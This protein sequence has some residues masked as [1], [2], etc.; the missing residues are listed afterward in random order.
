[1][2]S[3]KNARNDVR[4]YKPFIN[5]LRAIAIL[6]VVGSHVG[7]PGF[8][9]GYV[10]VDVF[11]VISGYLIINQIVADIEDRRFSPFEFGGRR[12]LRILPT[13][14]FVMVICLVLATTVFVQPEHKEFSESF[15]LSAIMLANHHFM[16]HQGY[17]DMAAF[18]KPLLHMWSLG[19][20]EQFY[21]VAPLILLGFAAI[22]RKMNPEN[23]RRTWGGLT[24]GLAILS[25]AACVAFTYPL[26]RA[27]V[28][29]YIM[30][31]HGWEFILGGIAPP[32]VL[33]LRRRPAWISNCLAISG[34]AAIGLAIVLFDDDTLYPSYRVALPA[35]G[36]MFIIVGGLAEPR[37]SIARALSTWPMINIGLVSYAWY[38]WHWPLLSFVRT[39]NFGGR[40]LAKE[41]A[42][43]ALS[44]ALAVLTYRFIEL[45]VKNWR[46]SH[47]TRLS[48]T[49]FV[50]AAS[51]VLVAGLGYVWS[52]RVA[53]LML[54]AVAGLEPVK[55]SSEYPPLLHRGLL[56]GD[57]HANAIEASLQE[58]ARRAGAKL[59]VTARAGCPPL[60]QT[61]V[62]DLVGNPALY[63]HPF[64][65]NLAF[66]DAEFLIISARWN[67]YLGLPPSDPFYHSAILVDKRAKNAPTG[68]YDV[69]ANGLAAT[70]AEAKRAGVRR[71]LIIG[72]SPEFPGYAPY[73]L[74]R[75]IR[76]GIDGC[77]VSRA[78]VDARR[79]RT[80]E[81]LY[82]VAAG[83]EDVRVIDPINL[84]CT[85]S[86]CQ[87]YN[88]RTL[89]FKD[90]NHLSP[91]GFE[92][93]Y[94]AYERDFLWALIGDEPDIK[95]RNSQLDPAAGAG[96][97][98]RIRSSR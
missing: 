8:A 91:A 7:V 92:L 38:L 22:T 42:V 88:G 35:V 93:L 75:A 76:V 98:A 2:Q 64:Y 57:S 74:M 52:M 21:L 46:R 10:G 51:C 65:E 3:S 95:V 4:T 79:A 80:M 71:I 78:A 34:V 15:F 62:T 37:N 67:Y 63:C 53:P 6:S 55:I 81:T 29:F 72:P 26:G 50:G 23:A 13:F 69:L 12:A 24:L 19:V 73:C 27:N 31:T 77:A 5:G 61:E 20:E 96:S 45:P 43:A 84:F 89:Y 90:T 58:Y 16:A 54:P 9:G 1:M 59:A 97:I 32:L 48:M 86:I 94:K 56:L 11:F 87:P 70:I 40:D 85:E 17:F 83:P 33:S 44:L 28:S 18:T 68:V 14:L 25:F 60:L 39:I 41:V 47:P 66:A 30:P 82:R 49:A 36:A